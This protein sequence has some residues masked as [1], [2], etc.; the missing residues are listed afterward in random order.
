MKEMK[1]GKELAVDT[2]TE[3]WQPASGYHEGA[4]W[5]VLRRDDEG[6][7]LTVLLNVPPGFLVPSHSHVCIEQHYVL[8]GDY[9]SMGQHYPAGTYRLIPAHSDHGPFVTK[10]GAVVLVTWQPEG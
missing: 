2:V 3:P 10:S 9:E 7:P 4:S 8:E 6:Q 5:K 1:L